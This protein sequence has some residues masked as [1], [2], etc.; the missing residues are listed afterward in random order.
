MAISNGSKSSLGSNGDS[1]GS[2]GFNSSFN[3]KPYR[4]HYAGRQVITLFSNLY[5]YS[6]LSKA[7]ER[8][9]GCG[10]RGIM[11]KNA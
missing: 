7:A 4:A 9:E 5:F 6:K 11:L 1:G 3:V 2:G 10:Q 8:M